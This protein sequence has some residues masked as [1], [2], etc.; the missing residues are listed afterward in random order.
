M[1]KRWKFWKIWKRYRKQ[2]QKPWIKA[3]LA[4][5]AMDAIARFP[6]HPDAPKHPLPGRL[7]VSMTSY[8]PRYPWLYRTLL[9]LLDQ[10]VRP[11]HILLWVAH[12]DFE[13]LPDEVLALQSDRLVI[14][15]CDDLRNFKRLVPA[16]DRYPGSFITFADDDMYYP[17]T[18]LEGLVTAYDPADPTVVCYRGSRIEYSADGKLASYRTWR[19]ARDKKSELPSTDLLPVNQ[20]G[21]L[22]PP[23]SLPP[24]AGDYELIQ[25]LSPTSDEVWLFFMWRFAGWRVR[26]VPG[27]LPPFAEWP[28]SQQEALWRMHRGGKKDEHFQA[29]AEYYGTP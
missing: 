11:D 7:I 24:H 28:G 8:P 25:K 18:W 16:L 10:T 5:R 15:T 2:K 29:M 27:D 4:R 26:R 9:S 20:T 17:D 6:R 22:Y 12:G 13:K 21:V 1:A 19:D 3:S 23:G 14:Q